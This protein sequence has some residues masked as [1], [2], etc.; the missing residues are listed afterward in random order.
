MELAGNRESVQE[1]SIKWDD[2]AEGEEEGL[3]GAKIEE[4]GR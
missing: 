1:D 2:R 3:K 4:G